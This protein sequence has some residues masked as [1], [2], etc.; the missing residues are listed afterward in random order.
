MGG[1]QRTTPTRALVLRGVDYGEADRILTLLTPELGRVAVLAR[2]ARKS[3]RR[4]AGALEP[5]AV[6]AAVERGPASLAGLD[7]DMPGLNGIELTAALRGTSAAEKMPLL[8]VTATGGA[9]DWRLLSS[10]G[11]DGF[12]VK[13][14]DP[15]ALVALARRTLQAR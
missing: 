3:Q 13:P 11:A 6:L 4:F 15:R 9:P 1:S 14:N 8:V 12:L 10:L 7:L 2:G 5:F